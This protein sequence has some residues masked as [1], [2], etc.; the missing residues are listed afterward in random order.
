M[1]PPNATAIQTNIFIHFDRF[2]VTAF[3]QTNVY[4]FALASIL[5][6]SMKTVSEPTSP[7]RRRPSLKKTHRT[8]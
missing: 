1:C 2:F 3:F 5:V 8:G 4:L 7:K 6:P